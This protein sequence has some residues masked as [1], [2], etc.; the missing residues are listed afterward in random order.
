M[1][2]REMRIHTDQ[3]QWADGGK[4]HTCALFTFE[5][6]PCEI[7][8]DPLLTGKVKDKL[9]KCSWYI[10]NHN[11]SVILFHFSYFGVKFG[12]IRWKKVNRSNYDGNYQLRMREI[13]GVAKPI[14]FEFTYVFQSTQTPYL[15]RP[16]FDFCLISSQF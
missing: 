9:T 2:T 6:W 15:Y 14:I 7:D 3:L 10:H 12:L 16:P 8:C 4:T 5:R 11:R 13:L 1:P